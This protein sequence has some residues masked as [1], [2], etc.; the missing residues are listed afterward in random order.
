M[1]KSILI[2]SGA[3]LLIYGMGELAI[4]EIADALN[5]GIAVNDITFIH[6]T[7]Y[8]T[9][10]IDG[11]LA[12]NGILLPSFDELLDDK[13]LYAK[14]F[15]TQ[16]CNMDFIT[17]RP[18]AECYG[19][20]RYIVQNTPQRPLTTK[21]LD[22]IYELP[23]MNNYH[24]D[25]EKLGGV[26]AISEIKFSLTSCRGCFG[27]CSFCALNFHQGRIVQVRSHESLVREAELMT[28]APDFKGNIH[29]VGG[30][31]ANFRRT[32]C[33]KQLAKGVCSEKQCLFPGPCKNLV[34]D[35]SDYVSLL[36][37]LISC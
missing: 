12:N 4:V 23:Y 32:A 24:P 19:N 33:D 29:D 30:P 26:P 36:R 3:D 34:A 7:V 1:K 15:Y 11:V 27:G 5:S 8:K 28:Q 31:T 14:S 25:Y 2:D 10:E 37:K 17:A 20:K 16:Y 35:H 13:L 18:L 6:G 21:E 9:R 22:D